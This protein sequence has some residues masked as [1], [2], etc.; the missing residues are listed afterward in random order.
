LS[1]LNHT[2]ATKNEA[3][4][5][6]NVL[7][8]SGG[9]SMQQNKYIGKAE[10]AS[11]Y[12]VKKKRRKTHDTVYKRVFYVRQKNTHRQL[13]NTFWNSLKHLEQSETLWCCTKP[14]GT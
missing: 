7:N 10:K 4:K 11:C 3:F 1:L 14:S 9:Q 12:E 6:R 13:F 5:N 8:N 2:E